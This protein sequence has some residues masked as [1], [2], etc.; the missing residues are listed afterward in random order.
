MDIKQK[1][2]LF[3]YQNR[4]SHRRIKF[5]EVFVDCELRPF[6]VKHLL[7]DLLNNKI[8]DLHP[9]YF[10]LGNSE[11]GV[12]KDFHNSHLEGK[13]TPV[14]G[15]QYVKDNYLS[16]NEPAPTIQADNVVYNTGTISSPVSQSDNQSS[17]IQATNSEPTTIARSFAKHILAPLLVAIAAGLI[18]WYLTTTNSNNNSSSP[19]TSNTITTQ[20]HDSTLRK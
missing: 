11:A 4:H 2:L 17:S 15:E 6:D 18:I 16:K 8:I 12:L 20:K 1:L 19:T 9:Y 3:L 10:E 7:L 13:L 5:N 14:V